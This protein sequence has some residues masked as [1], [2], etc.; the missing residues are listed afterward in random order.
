MNHE[1]NVLLGQLYAQYYDAVYHQC[2]SII[3]YNPRYYPLVED[4]VQDAF[5]QAVV[6]YHEYKDYNNP[7][8]WIVRVAQNK[9]KSKFRDELRHAKVV[10]PL[11]PGQSEDAT[12][13]VC[14]VDDE[15]ARRDTI[16]Q[17]VRIY[18]R[19]TDHEKKVFIAYFLNDMSQKETAESTGL[20]ENS[21]RA[22]V[23]RIRKRARSMRNTD[24]LLFIGAFFAALVTKR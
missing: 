15:L 24:F 8:G 9:V 16:E 7:I 13:S 17:I 5:V 21:V 3:D 14:S 11:F 18:N 4:C 10:S 1:R 22:A 19:L 20:T 23:K 12:F 2:L 6:D